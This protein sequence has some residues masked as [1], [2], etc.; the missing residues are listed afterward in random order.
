MCI[1]RRVL[2]EEHAETLTTAGNV[3]SSPLCQGKHAQ[4]GR[5]SLRCARAITATRLRFRLA[6]ACAGGCW[7]GHHP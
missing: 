6:G 2:G 3:V 1:W 5:G 7:P 4:A